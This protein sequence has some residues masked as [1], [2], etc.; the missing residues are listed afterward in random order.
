MSPPRPVAPR[1]SVPA[2]LTWAVR[3]HGLSPATALVV[4]SLCQLGDGE[5]ICSA[6]ERDI[7]ENVGI[8]RSAAQ[9]GILRLLEIQAVVDL[10]RESKRAPRKLRVSPSQ[11]PT[12]AQLRLLA[13]PAARRAVQGGNGSWLV[14]VD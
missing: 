12:A 2:W 9:R 13:T 1:F 5:W 7:A 11:P 3:E 14:R 8:A 4:I 10:G 6:S